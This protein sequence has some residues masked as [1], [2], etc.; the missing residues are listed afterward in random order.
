MCEKEIFCRGCARCT[1]REKK[2]VFFNGGV[3]AFLWHQS[4]RISV[5]TGGKCLHCTDKLHKELLMSLI[6]FWNWQKKPWK[7]LKTGK[8]GNFR[9]LLKIAPNGYLTQ[10]HYILCRKGVAAAWSEQRSAIFLYCDWTQRPPTE[11]A[12]TASTIGAKN[13]V[14]DKLHK[15]KNDILTRVFDSSK[16]VLFWKKKSFLEEKNVKILTF[17]LLPKKCACIV[18]CITPPNPPKGGNPIKKRKEV[19]HLES[20]KH[21]RSELCQRP[22]R[23]SALHGA[24]K[25][26]RTL[27]ALGSPEKLRSRQAV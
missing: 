10:F 23:P 20:F 7:W 27:Y 25:P 18:Q 5:K 11:S 26:I 3:T 17:W 19:T 12:R 4:H 14:S 9:P 8:S 16:K 22:S 1:V 13:A 24:Y 21:R 6:I 2:A 15:R